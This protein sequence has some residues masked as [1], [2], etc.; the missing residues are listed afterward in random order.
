MKPRWYQVLDRTPAHLNPEQGSVVMGFIPFLLHKVTKINENQ[1]HQKSQHL[2]TQISDKTLII[3]RGSIGGRPPH[4]RAHTHALETTFGASGTENGTCTLTGIRR[5]GC[6][7]VEE[8]GRAAQ[9][10]HAGVVSV[11]VHGAGNR[12]VTGLLW[13][14]AGGVTVGRHTTAA[15]HE[16][17]TKR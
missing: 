7:A 17:C 5:V 11:T 13:R 14:G 4:L 6:G 8:S 9:V 16:T 2:T 3:S 12:A 10:G 15:A 1:P